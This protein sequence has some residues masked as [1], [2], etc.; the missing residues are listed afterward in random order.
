[1]NFERRFI[2]SEEEYLHMIEMKTSALF[3]I[4]SEGGAIA[5]GAVNH[6][7]KALRV[8]GTSLG[9]AFQIQDD[10]LDMS[11]DTETL[12]KDIGNDIRNGKKTL[13]AV[14]SLTHAEDDDKKVLKTFFGKTTA[15]DKEVQ[16]VHSVFK[17]VG[18]IDYAK[19][20][21]KAYSSKAKHALDILEESA[22][23]QLLTDLAKYT[24]IREN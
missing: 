23:K 9:L 6:I 20:Q 24:I 12:G 16:Q 18:S 11:S 2:V 8:Y 15:T 3:R 17:N 4:A 19:Q 10:F 14:H 1:M 7:Q 13:I 22:A 5:G 21:A